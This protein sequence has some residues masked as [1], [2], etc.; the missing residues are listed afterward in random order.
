[1]TDT[2]ELFSLISRDNNNTYNK[3][4]TDA[5]FELVMEEHGSISNVLNHLEELGI[6]HLIRRNALS[7]DRESLLSELRK[8]S[9]W[10]WSKVV[11][12][13]N[14][15]LKLERTFPSYS[16]KLQET[17]DYNNKIYS[18]LKIGFKWIEG[19]CIGVFNE[20]D[21]Y[22]VVDGRDMNILKLAEIKKNHGTIKWNDEPLS[23]SQQKYIVGL[24]KNLKNRII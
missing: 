24:S 5:I 16:R 23:T 6:L 9:G 11:S 10:P 12:I 20:S 2:D 4:E 14:R 13:T 18:D 3:V 21:Y 17:L 19:R 22:Q 8:Y 15:V 1:M 7:S